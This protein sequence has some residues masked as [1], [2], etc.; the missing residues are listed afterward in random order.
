MM[1]VAEREMDIRF[2]SRTRMNTDTGLREHQV[3]AALRRI[4]EGLPRDLRARP[5]Y[6]EV[7]AFTKENA[8]TVIHLI[9]RR[10]KSHSHTKD[11]EF[12]RASM[13]EHWAAG[14]EDAQATLTHR[15]WIQRRL[16]EYGVAVFDL[17]LDRITHIAADGAREIYCA[18]EMADHPPFDRQRKSA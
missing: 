15:E 4:L 10:R 8:V 13:R 9:N 16:P 3:K 7:E 11:Y 6:R 14:V 1:D 2:S 17:G 5:E 12:S 18:T